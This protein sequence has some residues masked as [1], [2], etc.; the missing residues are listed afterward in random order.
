MGCY[1]FL[2]YPCTTAML[3]YHLAAATSLS[4]T[5]G[6][7]CFSKRNINATF[8]SFKNILDNL[9]WAPTC[10]YIIHIH[11]QQYTTTLLLLLV[12]LGRQVSTIFQS[13]TPLLHEG[14]VKILVNLIRAPTCSYIIHIQLQQYTTTLL[15]LLVCLGR[16]VWNVLQ[17]VTPMLRTG[18]TKKFYII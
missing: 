5:L 17:S 10:S 15:L 12:C 3:Q 14:R 6:L 13:V 1:L 18:H 9:T 8:W 2:H 7:E 11:V 16:Y 4:R